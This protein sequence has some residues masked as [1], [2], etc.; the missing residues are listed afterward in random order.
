M[1]IDMFCVGACKNNG[2]PD[3]SAGAGIV[4]VHQDDSGRVRRREFGF[5]LGSSNAYL[6]E[7]QTVRLALSS[8]LPAMRHVPTEIHL[9]T[10]HATKMLH[11]RDHAYT[12]V[13]KKH[14]DEVGKL[15]EWYAYYPKT[16]LTTEAKNHEDIVRAKELAK[17][18]IETNEEHDSGTIG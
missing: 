7:I 1:K 11:T 18:A 8:V 13:P 9:I 3:Q 6:A 5:P 15:R 2:K 14:A 4:L 10:Q 16:R 17:T 12:A